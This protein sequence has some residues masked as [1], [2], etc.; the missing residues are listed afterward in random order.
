MSN[1]EKKNIECKLHFLSN[2]FQ[3]DI[4]LIFFFFFTSTV[5]CLQSK[6][7]QKNLIKN[8]SSVL[9]ERNVR[10]Y[11]KQIFWQY[12]LNLLFASVFS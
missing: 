10:T 3:A 1:N 6:S 9:V 12:F 2:P 4:S 8:L 5:I 11:H 7:R